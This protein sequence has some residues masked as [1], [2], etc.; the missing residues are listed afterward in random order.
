MPCRPHG[1]AAVLTPDLMHS[2]CITVFYGSCIQGFPP[3]ASH[4]RIHICISLGTSIWRSIFGEQGR[5]PCWSTFQAFAPR[6]FYLGALTMLTHYFPTP[7]LSPPQSFLVHKCPEPFI[8]SSSTPRHIPLSAHDIT[9][10]SL[11]P[12]FGEGRSWQA[13]YSFL[14]TRLNYFS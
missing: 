12:I 8:Q 5:G 6:R 11:V 4:A 9:W 13:F 14:T 1:G 2:Q 3:S 10:S 7:N